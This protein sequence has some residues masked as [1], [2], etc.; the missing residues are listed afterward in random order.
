LGV[1]YNFLNTDL[2]MHIIQS[3]PLP[4]ENSCTH[5]EDVSLL[6][7]KDCPTRR[8]WGHGFKKAENE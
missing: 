7:L 4:C 2:K 3:V 5:F 1:G 6:T 8:L